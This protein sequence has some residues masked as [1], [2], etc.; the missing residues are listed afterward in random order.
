MMTHT[1]CPSTIKLSAFTSAAAAQCSSWHVSIPLLPLRWDFPE[2]KPKHPSHSRSWS[3]P[4]PGAI[5]ISATP[6][7]PARP[8]LPLTFWQQQHHQRRRGGI[9]SQPS[10]LP[11][12]IKLSSRDEE[13]MFI[14]LRVSQ[15]HQEPQVVRQQNKRLDQDENTVW[16]TF[17]ANRKHCQ[18]FVLCHRR[19]FQFPCYKWM[20]CIL[21]AHNKWQWCFSAWVRWKDYYYTKH[22]LMSFSHCGIFTC[23]MRQLQDWRL[24]AGLMNCLDYTRFWKQENTVELYET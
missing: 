13:M 18:L 17:S 10:P 3:H 16:D 21:S 22:L 1:S 9:F 20:C 4:D 8:T 14:Q 12:R 11:H 15:T 2:L 19:K 24:W 5:R 6:Q 23:Q 7:V